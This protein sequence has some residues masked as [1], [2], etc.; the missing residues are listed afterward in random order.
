MSVRLVILGILSQQPLHGYEIKH[1]IEDHMGDW[2][3]IKFG[4]IYFAL[5]K[6]AEAG[7][8]EVVEENHSGKRPAKTI[9]QITSKGQTEFLRLLKKMWTEDKQTIYPFDIA[10]FFM[11]K[12][13]KDEVEKYLKSRIE[14]L[15]EKLIFLKEH[16]DEHQKSPYIPQQV[17][18]IINHSYLH[19][20]AELKWVEQLLQNL[21]IYW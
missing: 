9:Y 19:L 18:A 4:S 7:D 20:E 5:S 8:I 3:D 1:I 10:I 21:D 11:N 2:T 12:L 15:E 17:F 6:L 16:K 13:T 14:A